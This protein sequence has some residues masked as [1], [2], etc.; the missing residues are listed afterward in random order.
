MKKQRTFKTDE[1]FIKT[2]RSVKPIRMIKFKEDAREL[3]DRE[4]TRMV[5]NA[6]SFK[7][8]LKELETLPRKKKEEFF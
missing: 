5:S 6:P 7:N 3:S 8:V 4:L 2:I 1:N